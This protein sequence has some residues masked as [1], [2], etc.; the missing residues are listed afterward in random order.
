MAAALQKSPGRVKRLERRQLLAISSLFPIQPR[1]PD[2]TKV[3]KYFR[4]RYVNIQGENG[5][6]TTVKSDKINDSSSIEVVVSDE[7]Q[8]QGFWKPLPA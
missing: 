5:D 8:T 4:Q 3:E 2:L 1:I 7:I 6:I